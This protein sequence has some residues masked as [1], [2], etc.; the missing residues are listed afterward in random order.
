MPDSLL[1]YS[2]G[3]LSRGCLGSL[4]SLR[5]NI[6]LNAQSVSALNIHIQSSLSVNIKFPRLSIYVT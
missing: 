3:S 5:K 4:M 1:A 6:C 2:S